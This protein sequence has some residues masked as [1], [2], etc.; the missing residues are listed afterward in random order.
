MATDTEKNHLQKWLTE[1]S[2]ELTLRSTVDEEAVTPVDSSEGNLASLVNEYDPIQGANWGE[3]RLLSSKILHA[4]Y[5]HRDVYFAILAGWDD[6]LLLIAPFS[7]YST[8]ATQGEWLT[9]RKDTSLRVLNLWN[10]HS[11]PASAIQTSWIVDHL[12]EVDRLHA[13]DVFWHVTMGDPLQNELID[14][15][16]PPII[17]SHDPRIDYQEEEVTLMSPIAKMAITWAEESHEPKNVIYIFRETLPTAMAA[18]DFDEPATNDQSFKASLGKAN[19]ILHFLCT[20]NVATISILDASTLNL[21]TLLD[22]GCIKGPNDK[23]LSDISQGSS[24][25]FDVTDFD[26]IEIFDAE[27]IPVDLEPIEE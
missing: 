27:G 18:K 12:S 13:L 26:Q 9:G 22:G 2:L 4:D 19:L 10:A 14:R 15:V 25:S 6:E 23:I 17:H 3:I 11:V 21:S 20:T 8:P 16:G 5:R 24:Q 7:R 1:R